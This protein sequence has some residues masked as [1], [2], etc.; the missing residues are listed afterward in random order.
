[1]AAF[2]RFF[3]PSLA[4]PAGR[5]LPIS[6][7]PQRLTRLRRKELI[8]LLSNL[9]TLIDNGLPLA[10][11]LYTLQRER[12]LRRHASLLEA[13]RRHVETGSP[14]SAALA[15][16]PTSFNN[17]LICQVR[18][19]ERSATLARTLQRAAEHL[20]QAEQVRGQIIRKLS[21][22]IVLM[23]AGMAA[24]TFMLLFVVPV[25]EQA[26]SG[27]GVPLPWITR[28]LIAVSAGAM[29]YGWLL[30]VT[31]IAGWLALRRLRQLPAAACQVDRWLL[32]VPLL[33]DWWRNLV[34]LQFI[35]VLGNLLEAG[36]KVVDALEVSAGAVTNQALLRSVEGLKSAVLRGER[37]SSELE[38]LGDLFPPVVGQ[39]VLVGEKTG[40]LS[41]AT[42]GIRDHL[43]R[44]VE[45]Q[46]NLLVGTL[47]PVLTILLAVMVGAV[48]LAIYLPMFD[49][50]KVMDAR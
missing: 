13:V 14:F 23:I 18:A 47:E 30:P 33:G 20:D 45:H 35:D 16:F 19:G 28:V 40:D 3:E 36:F 17:M 15:Q 44:Q 31:V 26:Y 2:A 5:T 6:A 9:G 49:M 48:L 1:M 22:P 42:S 8:Y 46:T 12:S 34:V 37:F 43:R 24:V 32:T 4:A 39:L 29:R 38:N 11:A 7:S 50:I 41:K 21:Y 10:K 27:A 25:F